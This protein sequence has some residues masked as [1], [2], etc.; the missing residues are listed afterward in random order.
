MIERI[1]KRYPQ[2]YLAPAEG[3][4]G[5][6]MYRIRAK[7]GNT[8]NGDLSHFIG[9]PGD[10]CTLVRTPA[11]VVEVL[12]FGLRE[13]FVTALRILKYRCEPVEIREDT[14]SAMLTGLTDWEKVRAH[15][16]A[17]LATG[18][19]DW[20]KEQ[21]RFTADRSRCTSPILLLCEGP[22]KGIPAKEAGMTEEKWEKV[23]GSI[24]RY[25]ELALYCCGQ[26]WQAKRNAGWDP[27]MAECIGI[28]GALKTY[29]DMLAK[30][31]LTNPTPAAL[32]AV[33][34]LQE[35]VCC[36]GGGDPFKLLNFLYHETELYETEV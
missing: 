36:W 22:Y 23:S 16:E 34:A 31:F 28:F 10:R 13:D 11:G 24:R 7:E 21:R 27:I 26:K 20:E 3:A 14:D 5:S 17:Y 25:R 19:T 35:T 33:D 18:C 2:M 29:D 12:T 30:K 9:S 8:E 1:A 15:K 6:G 4:S 32:R